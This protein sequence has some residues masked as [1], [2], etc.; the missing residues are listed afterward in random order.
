MV[1]LQITRE[2]LEVVVARLSE[3]VKLS[4]E[5]EFDQTEENLKSIANILSNIVGFIVKFNVMISE[6]V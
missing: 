6:N 2:T 1:D 3:I 5:R 4:E